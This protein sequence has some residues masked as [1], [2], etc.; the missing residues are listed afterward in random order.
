MGSASTSPGGA[1]APPADAATPSAME[2]DGETV[3]KHAFAH[4]TLP[5][6]LEELSL[7]RQ[8]A[9][10][11]RLGQLKRAV[12]T[13]GVRGPAGPF[14][15]TAL[16]VS[17]D[18]AAIYLPVTAKQFAAL[19]RGDRDATR[20]SRANQVFADLIRRPIK[21]ATVELKGV[22]ALVWPF[23][24]TS[25]SASF[26]LEPPVNRKRGFSLQG[27]LLTNQWKIGGFFLC[28]WQRKLMVDPRPSEY[29]SLEPK[30]QRDFFFGGFDLHLMGQIFQKY[31]SFGF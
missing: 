26:T 10:S 7:G 1:A 27:S 18:G 24:V 9:S 11:S 19:G 5:A 15:P 29:I 30:G 16:S 6:N 17:P 12:T 20:V 21:R 8:A 23:P 2:V 4:V 13:G 3:F 22:S 14:R 25:N 28:S 31:G